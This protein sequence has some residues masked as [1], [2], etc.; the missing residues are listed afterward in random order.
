MGVNKVDFSEHLRADVS[1]E[2]AVH[3]LCLCYTHMCMIF[4]VPF[5][6]SKTYITRRNIKTYINSPQHAH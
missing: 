5:S 3:V 6:V 4:L 1:S 2:N